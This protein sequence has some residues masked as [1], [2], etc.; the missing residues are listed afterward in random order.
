V[1]YPAALAVLASLDQYGIKPGLERIRRL[2]EL[3]G[4]PERQYPIVLVAGTN[5]KGSTS[6]FLASILTAAGCRVGT[7]PKPHLYT[8]RERLQVG[9]E[10]C[11]EAA[12]AAL[13]EQIAPWL[14]AVAAEPAAGPPSYFE[15]MTLMALLWFARQRVDWAVVEVGLGGRLDATNV[16]EPAASVITNIGLD[17]TD[18]LGSTLESI[19]RE[20][21]GILR[22]GVPAVTGASGPALAT[23]GAAA[24]ERG[25]SLWRLGSEVVPDL[26][27][28][29]DQ[30]SRFDLRTPAGNWTDL[31][32]SLPGAHQ[33]A[34]ASLA[35]ATAARLAE[36]GAPVSER[37]IRLGLAA[38]AF[39]G[40]LERLRE[41]PLLLIDAAHNPDAARRL[42][43]ALHD[44]YLAPHPTRRLIL[45]LALSQ[46]HQPAEMAAILA[47]PAQRLV[48]T[49]SGHPQ[50]VP[51]EQAAA[52]ARPHATTAPILSA[53]VPQAVEA[54]LALARPEDV[55]C[56]TGSIFA[57]G[58]V[59]RPP[60]SPP[61][62]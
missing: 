3:T 43:T 48:V 62:T 57:I 21:A 24:A 32:I 30:G 44:L 55:I 14:E 59:P 53:S 6:A 10:L 13:V 31:S 1:D 8:P 42:V 25:A 26:R 11:S 39:P 45:V 51:A 15:A 36:R 47:P 4:H 54:A 2:C 60:A 16:V 61:A 37:A 5:G 19:A 41:R 50:A 34:N 46:A 35:A 17:H 58:E 7:A 23:I 38:A 18:R 40:R 12:F 9:G 52:L 33:V 29:D 28:P 49:A 27:H 20:K 22:P 56:V